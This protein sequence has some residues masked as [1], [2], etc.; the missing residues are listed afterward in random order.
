MLLGVVA[1]DIAIIVFIFIFFLLRLSSSVRFF[2]EFVAH[3]YEFSLFWIFLRV[4]ARAVFSVKKQF[5]LLKTHVW[6]IIHLCITLHS[7]ALKI[8]ILFFR[9]CEFLLEVLRI[10]SF[11]RWANRNYLHS[12]SFDLGG[13]IPFVLHICVSNFAV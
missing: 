3:F 7:H 13:N 12:F 8:D 6:N 11:S 2:F 4:R 1:I 10:F 5:L 9:F